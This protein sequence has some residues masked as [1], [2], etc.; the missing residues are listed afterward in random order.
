MDPTVFTIRGTVPES[1]LEYKH[2]WTV[3]SKH[4]IKLEE[5]WH[6]KSDGTLA[7]NN[8]HMYIKPK[9]KYTKKPKYEITEGSGDVTI[10]LNGIGMGGSQAK[11]Q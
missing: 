7:R 5:F 3:V 11:M 1:E 6:F 8:V 4:E 10:G 9:R 2:V